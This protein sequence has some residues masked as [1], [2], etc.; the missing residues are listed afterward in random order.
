MSK[1]KCRFCGTKVGGGEEALWGH[2]QLGHPGKFEEVRD[3]ETPFMLE[4]CYD[5]D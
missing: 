2:I 4:T 3:L 5:E 1:W